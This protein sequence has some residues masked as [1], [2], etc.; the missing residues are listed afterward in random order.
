MSPELIGLLWQSCLETFYMVAVS[1]IVSFALGVPLGV[2]LT[3]TGKGHIKENL[4][5]NLG[6]GAAI[7][8]VRSTP[9]II[10]MV[11]IVPFTRWVAGTS[12]GTSA[13]IVPLTVSA[14]PFVARIVESALKEVPHGVVEAALSMGATPLE[15]I[16][17]VL[18]PEA[19]SGIILGLT[20]TIVSLIGYS[21][22][23]GVIG[24]GGLGDLAIRYGYQRFEVN[25]MIATVAI[26]ILIVQ[27]VQSFGDF[28]SRKTD[29]SR[30]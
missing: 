10:L 12:I 3:V 2:L 13:A 11:A 7:N 20:L 24:G 18:L 9:F 19:L 27:L 30:L 21:A 5:L 17:K 1:S 25:V 4:T 29:K 23:A 6:A 15:V 26:L 28:L 16:C 8:A 14:T 22:M